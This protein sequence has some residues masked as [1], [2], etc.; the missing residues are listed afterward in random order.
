M[1]WYSPWKPIYC[2]SFWVRCKNYF[3]ANGVI[4][5]QQLTD[6]IKNQ[7]LGER[8][9]SC[10]IVPDMFSLKSG[11]LFPMN[12]ITCLLITEELLSCSKQ[13]LL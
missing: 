8:K 4:N 6:G 3:R 13:S 1:R 7:V 5:V 10:S 2:E 12:K 9:V 11:F